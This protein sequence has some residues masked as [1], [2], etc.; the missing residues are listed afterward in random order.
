MD[1]ETRDSLNEVVHAAWQAFEEA[2]KR[3]LSV[4]PSMP[5]LFF[6]DV[7]RYLNSKTRVVTVGLNPSW[8]EFPEGKPWSRFPNAAGAKPSDSGRYLDALS[9]YFAKRPYKSWFSSYEQMLNGMDASYY[10]KRL[11]TALH[12]DICSPVPTDPTWSALPAARQQ[13]L[14]IEGEPLWQDLVQVLEPDIV[15]LSIARQHLEHIRFTSITNWNN[16]G[17]FRELEGGDSHDSSLPL[18]LRWYRISNKK[19]LFVHVRAGRIPLN[20][21]TAAQRKSAGAMA[22]REFRTG[23][24][25]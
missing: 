22:L 1:A 6:G 18:R 24:K 9:E 20:P 25:T 10:G 16:H 13:E 5:I 8:Q 2:R 17:V 4:D 11:S 19:T 15:V 14:E 7:D 21:L 23:H 3:N 12:T